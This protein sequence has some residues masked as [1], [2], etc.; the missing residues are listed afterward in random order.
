MWLTYGLW[1]LRHRQ[2]R[3]EGAP[4]E[5]GQEERGKEEKDDKQAEGVRSEENVLHE[6]RVLFLLYSV[7]EKECSKFSNGK[8]WVFFSVNL[9][10]ILH[11]STYDI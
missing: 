5:I 10:E 7:T 11:A 9:V 4:V 2:T 6:R 3:R 1:N 8:F